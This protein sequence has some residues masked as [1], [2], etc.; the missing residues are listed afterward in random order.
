MNEWIYNSESLMLS[1]RGQGQ[2]YLYHVVYLTI[3]VTVIHCKI[4]SLDDFMW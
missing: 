3:C 2:F 1:W 4:E